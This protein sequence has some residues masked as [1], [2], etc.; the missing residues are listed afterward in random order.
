MERI[1]EDNFLLLFHIVFLIIESLSEL[2]SDAA[3]CNFFYKLGQ[4]FIHTVSFFNNTNLA[5]TLFNIFL[6]V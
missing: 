1:N 3:S 5:Y 4:L 2:I 6:L